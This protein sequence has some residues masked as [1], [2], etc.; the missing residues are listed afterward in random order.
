MTG[1]LLPI[2]AFAIAATF[3]PLPA[4]LAAAP[5]QPRM[6]V[7]FSPG[8]AEALVIRV[9]DG[10]RATIEVAAY[11]FTSRPVASALLRARD[12]GVT[13]RIVAD[14]SQRT[15]RYTSVRYLARQGVPVRIDSRYSIMHDKFLIVDERTVETGSFNY[16][17]AA[18]LRN[19]ENVVVLVDAPAVAAAY[20]R[21]WQR[22]WAESAPFDG[23]D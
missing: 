18:A 12:R 6:E 15:A 10:A 3:A 5:P 2:V 4:V 21:E 20:A 11:S 8:D 19:A 16:T 22:L 23:H 17:R 13:V 1:R 9:I 14:R 7:G